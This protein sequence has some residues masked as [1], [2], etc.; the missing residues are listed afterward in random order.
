MNIIKNWIA[1]CNNLPFSVPFILLFSFILFII[2][3]I[4]CICIW[5]WSGGKQ[6]SLRHT[7]IL[8]VALRRKNGN[9]LEQTFDERLSRRTICHAWADD[10]TPR[11]TER[12]RGWIFFWEK[13][14]QFHMIPR[15]EIASIGFVIF[16]QLWFFSHLH[17]ICVRVVFFVC[18]LLL[19]VEVSGFF[20]SPAL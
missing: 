20:A 14:H 9:V 6:W 13:A 1:Y 11:Q 17:C 19:F 4:V 7:I 12:N 8:W 15:S 3:H 16:K 10:Q 2:L 18:A 5:M